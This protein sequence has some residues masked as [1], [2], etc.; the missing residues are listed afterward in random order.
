MTSK[1]GSHLSGTS[2]AGG[3]AVYGIQAL[4]GMENSPASL[5]GPSCW[6]YGQHTLY[7][8][9]GRDPSNEVHDTLWKYEAALSASGD[10]HI[11][12]IWGCSFDADKNTDHAVL[13]SCGSDELKVFYNEKWSNHICRVTTIIDGKHD[14]YHHDT[15]KHAQ[16][17]TICGN[18]VGFHRYY[19]GITV[20]VMKMTNYDIGGLF[21]DS[22]CLSDGNLGQ[23]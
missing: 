3:S 19:A 15:L 8:S 7:V 22:R 4:S 16:I 5:R 18:V 17:K 1:E 10:P 21:N 12:S 14:R 23:F 11:T 20:K 2:T 9:F 13:M 6:Q